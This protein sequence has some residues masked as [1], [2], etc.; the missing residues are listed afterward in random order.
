ML[1]LLL[2][3]FLSP[4]IAQ[5][6]SRDRVNGQHDIDDRKWAQKSGLP[7]SEV[8]AIRSAAGITHDT[9]GSRIMTIDAVSLKQRNHVL[10]VEGPCVK[11][12]VIERRSHGFAEVWSLSA[13]PDPPWK[14]GARASRPGRGICPQAPRPPNAHATADGRIVLEVPILLDAFQRTLPADTYSFA[15]DGSRYVLAHAAPSPH[16]LF[17]A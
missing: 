9:P 3:A 1:G 8:Q 5:V 14:P 6:D 7:V 15:W 13:L 16:S 17:K 12:H 2:L 11:L 4:V 10:L